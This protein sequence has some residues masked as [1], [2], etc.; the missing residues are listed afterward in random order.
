MKRWLMLFLFFPAFLVACDSSFAPAR[1]R[2]VVQW[3][4]GS[5]FNT[6]GF[7][8]Y[9]SDAPT[10]PFTKINAQLIPAS[11]DPVSGGK[12][13]Y[14]D[15]EVAAGKTYYYE[16]EDIEYGGVTARHGPIV[17]T[18][19]SPFPWEFGLILGGVLLVGLILLFLRLRLGNLRTR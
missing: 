7:N 9:R 2:I 13:E 15:T 3:T 19:S 8:L 6:A 17:A 14:E 11:P 16:L 10:G 18:A 12:Y 5:E 4:T 1:P